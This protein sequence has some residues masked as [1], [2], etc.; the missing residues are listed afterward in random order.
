MINCRALCY[1]TKLTYSQNPDDHNH[2]RSLHFLLSQLLAPPK[3]IHY[4]GLLV[5]ELHLSESKQCM[6]FGLLASF[7][8]HQVCE[9]YLL[10]L[11]AIVYSFISSDHLCLKSW[12]KWHGHSWSTFKVSE[13]VYKLAFSTHCE[14]I[15]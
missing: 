5:V 7:T 9:V 11:I 12:E 2:T 3:G 1:F 6:L 14:S 10:S 8:H 13:C 4:L 15:F